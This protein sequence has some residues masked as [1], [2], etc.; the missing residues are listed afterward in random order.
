MN[1]TRTP[2]YRADEIKTLTEKKGALAADMQALI[3]TA[4]TE[5]RA[6]TDEENE[7][8]NSIEAEIKAIDRTLDAERRAMAL[9]AEKSEDTPE[10]NSGTAESEERAFDRY[11]RA[12]AQGIAPEV[13]AGEQNLTMG[14]NGAVIPVSIVNT[15]IKKVEEICPVFARSTQF[16]A[17]GTIK[18]PVWGKANSTHDITVAYQEEFSELTADSGKFSSVDLSGYLAGA[19]TLIGESVINNSDIPITGFIVEEMAHKIAA[20]IEKECLIGTSGK[21]SGVLDGTN[22]VTGTSSAAITSDN[23]IEL[24]AA[25]PTVYQANSCWTM[26]PSTFTALKKLKDSTGMYLLQRDITSGFPYVLLGKPVYLSDNMPVMGADA[27]A[28]VYGDYAGLATNMRQNID[29]KVLREKYATQH[30]IGIVAWLEFDSKIIDNQKLAV[31]K[32][33]SATQA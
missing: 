2:E 21:A 13:R 30:A 20:F 19:L 4:R 25:V 5:V 3:D 24:Q 27:K 9:A 29:M 18:V 11:V 7:R 28:V 23:L 33:G 12:E 8:F 17:K 16:S 6:M 10:D 31:F 1:T 14:N 26:H 22:V 15:I 32:M